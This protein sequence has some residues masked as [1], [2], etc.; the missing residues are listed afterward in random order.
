MPK[1]FNVLTWNVGAIHI[2]G[3]YHPVRYTKERMS[4]LPT[5]L[6]E[7]GADLIALQELCLPR[8]GADIAVKM[9]HRYPYTAPLLKEKSRQRHGLRILSRYPVRAC[10]AHLFR[11]QSFWERLFLPKGFIFCVVDV[12]EIGSV[13]VLNAHFVAGFTPDA[14]DV[15]RIRAAQIEELGRFMHGIAGPLVLAC[16]LNA[17]PDVAA[18][19]NYH[20][21]RRLGLRDA[22]SAC[23]EITWD[24]GNPLLSAGAHRDCPAQRC[25][26]VF[27]N[28]A[29]RVRRVETRFRDPCVPTIGR[30]LV[31]ASD[32]RGVF[33]EL[34]WIE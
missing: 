21:V 28:D 27:H 30:P 19:Q 18:P 11:A 15:I 12:P 25:D 7:S 33:A 1:T 6:Q 34:E 24:P 26:F 20:D 17:A 8:A 23:D 9:R 5:L 16:D 14:S 4:H 31:H 13:T 10:D 2:G 3:L 22:G 29:W 32:H